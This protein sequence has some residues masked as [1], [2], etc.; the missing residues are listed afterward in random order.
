MRGNHVALQ[1]NLSRKLAVIFSAISIIAA[2]TLTVIYTSVTAFE[3]AS[4][5]TVRTYQVI[6]AI[7]EAEIAISRQEGRLR[8]YLMTGDQSYADGYREDGKLVTQFLNSAKEL[9]RATVRRLLDDLE[10]TATT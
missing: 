1:L 6:E 5:H 10:R 4:D 2:S 3:A 9:N 7:N 8:G